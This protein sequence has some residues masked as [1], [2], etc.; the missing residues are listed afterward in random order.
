M[1]R[2]FACFLVLLMAFC[3]CACQERGMYI[4]KAK[5]SKAEESIVKLLGAGSGSELIYD[6]KLDENVRSISVSSYE[7][8]DGQWQVI[9]GGGGL[10]FEEKEGRLALQ[11]DRIGEE[12]RVAIQGGDGYFSAN[13]YTTEL[14]EEGNLGHASAS[15]VD[16]A[17]VEYGKEIPLAVQIVTAQSE[18]RSFA[19]D[20]FF[21][22]EEYAQYGYEHVYAITVM[23]DTEGLE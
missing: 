19:S 18:I 16:R 21:T 9:T 13:K 8:V 11:F 7:L 22:P 4:Q 14:E 12:L 5:L 17:Q 10:A 15:L 23:F 20:Y 6:F 1:K 3:L 2:F